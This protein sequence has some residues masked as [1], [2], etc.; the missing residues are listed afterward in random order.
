MSLFCGGDA[1]DGALFLSFDESAEAMVRQGEAASRQLL[2]CHFIRVGTELE[3]QRALQ[4]ATIS[5]SVPS[6]PAQIS[7]G[8]INNQASTKNAP[9]NL[10]VPPVHQ[11]IDAQLGSKRRKLPSRHKLIVAKRMS[12]ASLAAGQRSVAATWSVP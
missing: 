9:H 3:A 11:S 5:A 12:Q 7:L 1:N 4:A 10:P 2:F 8:I 6:N